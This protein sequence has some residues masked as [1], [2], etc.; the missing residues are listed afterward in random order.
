MRKIRTSLVAIMSTLF[1]PTALAEKPIS[2]GLIFNF[3]G[4]SGA[5]SDLISGMEWKAQN[6]KKQG[7]EIEFVKLSSKDSTA[8]S[9]EAFQ[10]LLKSGKHFDAV[11]AELDSS[12]AYAAADVADQQGQVM[13]TPL[14]TSYKVTEG[15]TFV[16][17]GTFS[18]RRQGR[19]G[20]PKNGSVRPRGYVTFFEPP[21][22]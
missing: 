21:F 17:S 16:F 8:G 4:K 10:K 20:L 14:S 19:A 15:R 1:F 11:I 9:R 18:D 13:F 6:L 12:K 22:S 5:I 2:V 3:E 7:I